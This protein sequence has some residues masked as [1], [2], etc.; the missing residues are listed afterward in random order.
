MLVVELTCSAE[1]LGAETIVKSFFT[2]HCTKCHG[3]K[4]QEGDAIRQGSGGERV[5]FRKLSRDE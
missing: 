5:S 1:T 3:E 4:K 2:Q